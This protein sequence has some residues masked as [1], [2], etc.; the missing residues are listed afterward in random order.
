MSDDVRYARLELREALDV[1]GLIGKVTCRYS[2]RLGA[3]TGRI[4]TA[5]PSE[6]STLLAGDGRWRDV[7]ITDSA[8]R[9]VWG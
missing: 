3:M 5:T 1:A 4:A 9:V 6:V 7:E 8:V 2:Q